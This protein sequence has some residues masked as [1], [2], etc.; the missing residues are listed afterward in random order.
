[1][2]VYEI[3]RNSTLIKSTLYE[4][5]FNEKINEIKTKFPRVKFYTKIRQIK[6]EENYV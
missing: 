2:K 6:K 3:W 4:D 5:E 1:M